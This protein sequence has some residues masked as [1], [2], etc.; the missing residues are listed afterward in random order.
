MDSP[1]DTPG[2]DAEKRLER[3]E[4]FIAR[5]DRDDDTSTAYWR[6]APPQAHARAMAELA[7]YAARMARQTGIGK[8]PDERFPGF[9]PPRTSR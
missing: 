9:P 6:T 1:S 4:R 7:D 2:Q 8:D 3:L 5:R